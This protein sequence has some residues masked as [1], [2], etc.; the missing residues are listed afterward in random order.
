MDSYKSSSVLGTKME[1]ASSFEKAS[2][3]ADSNSGNDG[4]FV[5]PISPQQFL[6]SWMSV[7]GGTISRLPKV[8]FSTV[9][10]TT[11]E[12]QK[13]LVCLSILLMSVYETKLLLGFRYQKIQA[14][15]WN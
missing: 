4:S 9:H 2:V 3:Y 12:M 7:P 1:S 6:K 11:K 13:Q 8:R 14:I 10:G 15:S 5:G